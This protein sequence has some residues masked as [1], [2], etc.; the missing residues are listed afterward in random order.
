MA[1]V[2]KAILVGNLGKDPEIHKGRDGNR[3]ASFSVAT[4]VTWRD[5]DT[6]ER[7]ERTD[8][9]RVVIFN[10]KLAEVAEKYLKK[11]SRVYVEGSNQTRKYTDK[12]QEERYITEVV[13]SVFHSRLEL[14][15]KR[16][17]GPRDGAGT[18]AQQPE[19]APDTDMDIP[20]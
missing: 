13:L 2:N 19:I 20:F 14:L 9:H 8:W 10:D 12:N 7:R 6:G 11:G 1:G 15:D 4:G 18:G 5:R 17:G 16:E 3:I